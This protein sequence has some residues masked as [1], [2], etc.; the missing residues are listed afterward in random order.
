[1][2]GELT[3]TGHANW[4]LAAALNQVLHELIVD[5]TDLSETA[6]YLG[7]VNGSGSTVSKIAQATWD[8]AMAASNTDEVTASDPTDVTNSTVSI[9]VA[10][11][12]LVRVVTELYQIIGEGGPAPGI[13]KLANEMVGSAILRFTDMITA[14]YTSLSGSAGVSGSAMVVDDLYDAAYVLLI[15]GAGGQK[16]AVLA[17]IQATHLCHSIRA[18]GGTI[19]PTD[20]A[21]MLSQL[22]NGPGWGYVGTFAQM[23]IISCDSVATNGSDREGALYTQGCFGYK[24]GIPT[25]EMLARSVGSRNMPLPSGSS[26]FVKFGQ[27]ETKGWDIVV[28][29]W[30]VG[31][32]EIED[33]RGCKIVTS[34]S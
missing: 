20:A 19:H 25:S 24:D 17:P 7:N 26:I 8:D 34:A 16:Y 29:S 2:S 27:D 5:K 13:E 23:Q 31:V 1:M 30:F 15:N 11:Q 6:S 33:A 18:E 10:R 9:T 21:S 28:G 32:G 14:L 4:F 3:Y 12:A 22:G